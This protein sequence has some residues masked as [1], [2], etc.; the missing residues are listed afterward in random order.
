MSVKM[1]AVEKNKINEKVEEREK[2]PE[3]FEELS[4]LVLEQTKEVH[5]RSH[6]LM[7]LRLLKSCL[8]NLKYS[9]RLFSGR[10]VRMFDEVDIFSNELN[11][12]ICTEYSDRWCPR[13]VHKVGA[14]LRSILRRTPGVSPFFIKRL[15]VHSQRT[16]R[17]KGFYAIPKKWRAC[18]PEVE[19]R[20]RCCIQKLRENT[21]VQSETTVRVILSFFTSRCTP[22]LDLKVLDWCSPEEPSSSSETL[23]K[24]K[25]L[26]KGDNDDDCSSVVLKICKSK[27]MFRRV[28]NLKWLSYFLEYALGADVRPDPSLEGKFVREATVAAEK[29]K[30]LMWE[31]EMGEAAEMS[32]P[33]YCFGDGGSNSKSSSSFYKDGGN[34]LKK[35]KCRK[36]QE[37]EEAGEFGDVHRISVPD[38][39]RLYSASRKLGIFEELFFLILISTGM[40]CTGLVRI[41]ILDVVS[42]KSTKME[43]TD[44]EEE[45]NVQVRDYGVTIEKYNRRFKFPLIPRVKE[46]IWKYLKEERPA[47]T[48]P[49]LFPGTMRDGHVTHT[50]ISNRFRKICQVAGLKGRQFHPHALRHSYAH[51]LHVCGNRPEVVSKMLGHTSVET[52]NRY[53]LPESAEDVIHRA[54][55]PWLPPNSSPPSSSLEKKKLTSGK[56]HLIPQFLLL[57]FPKSKTELPKCEKNKKRLQVLN[58]LF[59]E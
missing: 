13:T 39:D 47:D 34:R 55:I 3:G 43:Q 42:F 12:I 51:M 53:Y 27:D 49:Y 6:V 48:S 9:V 22:N 11:R 30:K 19:R 17:P 59:G 57:P 46:L 54:H 2:Q 26:I 21:S 5:K 28:K 50:V 45:S 29:G 37:E 23:D 38:L 31:K 15:R 41:R 58:D 4:R 32:V 35:R 16:L 8:Q 20:I 40:R 33:Q 25:R 56:K 44:I 52:T 1:K 18:G 10:T 24:V 36:D 7:A 14:I